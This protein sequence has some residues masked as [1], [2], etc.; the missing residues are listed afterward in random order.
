M[1]KCL[2]SPSLKQR[3]WQIVG[4]NAFYVYLL[5]GKKRIGLM[6]GKNLTWTVTNL[7]ERNL[8]WTT[9]QTYKLHKTKPSA[10]EHLWLGVV[11]SEEPVIHRTR[12]QTGL[13]RLID[14][15]FCIP[16]RSITN[17]LGRCDKEGGDA[18]DELKQTFYSTNINS[19]NGLY[20]L[21]ISAMQA[22][23]GCVAHVLWRCKTNRWMMQGGCQL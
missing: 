4:Y 22:V 1:T 2:F 16:I 7:N 11:I 17:W 21:A 5:C 6:V 23:H 13:H 20:I 10:G 18:R 3:K 14:V 8:Q 12:H 19:H 15:L 9:A